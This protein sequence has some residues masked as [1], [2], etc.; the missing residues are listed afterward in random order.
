MFGYVIVNF[1]QGPV[2]HATMSYFL[3]C[4]DSYY[5]PVGSCD[6]IFSGLINHY[7]LGLSLKRVIISSSR[8]VLYDAGYFPN[9]VSGVSYVWV[10]FR[11]VPVRSVG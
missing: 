4:D 11:L 5:G 9:D 2:F 3:G 1:T 10:R 8:Q 6:I 7:N